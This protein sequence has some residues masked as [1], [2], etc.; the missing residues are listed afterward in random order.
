MKDWMQQG[1]AECRRGALTGCASPLREIGQSTG[2]VFLYV[3]D[4]C[5]AYWI[6][7]LR[8]AHVISETEARAVLGPAFSSRQNDEPER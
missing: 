7:N 6:E 8:E 2:P 5:G 1:C 3:C 4:V